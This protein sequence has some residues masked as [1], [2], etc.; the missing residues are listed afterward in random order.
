MDL[1]VK[2]QI[3][4]TSR[5][6]AVFLCL[7]RMDAHTMNVTNVELQSQITRLDQKVDERHEANSKVL[8]DIGKKMDTLIELNVGQRLQA[9]LIGQLGETTKKHDAYFEESFKR[10]AK[11][12]STTNAHGWAWKIVGAVLLTSIGGVGWMLVQMK[13][14]Y[15]EFYQYQDKVDTLQFIVQG[16]PAVMTP[17]VQPTTAK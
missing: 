8:D 3:T 4:T 15:S 16:R 12:E 1:S 13:E 17:P 2:R 14:F 9:Q 11:V 6:R 5:L 7:D 10:L